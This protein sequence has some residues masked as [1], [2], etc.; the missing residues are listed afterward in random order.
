MSGGMEMDPEA[1]QAFAAVLAD[2]KGKFD[3]V[4]ARFDQSNATAEDFGRSWHEHGTLF[5]NSWGKLAPD[6]GSLSILLEQI[7]AQLGQTAELV[8]TGETAAV[9]DF[10]KIKDHDTTGSGAE[11][12]SAPPSSAGSMGGFPLSDAWDAF[13]AK[14]SDDRTINQG[15]ADVIRGPRLDRA[16]QETVPG[17]MKRLELGEE[18][19]AMDQRARLLDLNWGKIEHDAGMLSGLGAAM[20][21]LSAVLS[22]GAAK[23]GDTWKG[24]SY[25]S[26]RT[27]VGK[28]TTTLTAYAQGATDTGDG[29]TAAM[30][31][32]RGLYEIYAQETVDKHLNFD[33]VSPPANWHK[34]TNDSDNDHS[35]ASLGRACCGTFLCD[36]YLAGMILVNT[37][38]TD[39]QWATCLAA[40]CDNWGVNVQGTIQN[41]A[42]ECAKRVRDIDEQIKNFKNPT[43]ETVGHVTEMMDLAVGNLVE[44]AEDQVLSSLAIIGG[45]GTTPANAGDYSGGGGDYPGGGSYPGSGGGSAGGAGSMPVATPP[46]VEM[47]EVP[48]ASEVPEFAPEAVEPPADGVTPEQQETVRIQDGD[49]AISVSSPDGSGQVRVTVEDASGATKS[50]SLDFD[51]ASGLLPMGQDPAAAAEPA[52][53]PDGKPI[54]DEAQKIPA[55]TNGK[56]VIEDGPL[57]ITAERPLFAPDSLRLVVDD[58][59]GEPTTYTV[60]FAEQA[61]DPTGAAAGLPAVAPAPGGDQEIAPPAAERV[62]EDV[63]AEPEAP[64]E[65]EPLVETVDAE[66]PV[67]EALVAEP[68]AETEESEAPPVDVVESTAPQSESNGTGAMSGRLPEPG[69]AELGVAADDNGDTGVAAA[70][71]PM[72]GGA[73]AQGDSGDA[74][75][76]I[77]SGWSVHGDLFDSGEPVYSMRGVLGDDERDAE[78]VSR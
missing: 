31:N 78:Q 32:I 75:G 64:A 18:H 22:G 49:R 10:N 50:Y 29:L 25:Q 9:G 27:A 23:L 11:E 19:V 5:V 47:P 54:E 16:I 65:D 21:D 52:V 59:T 48:E 8:V 12:S 36:K 42:D 15:F 55:S 14:Q 61:D 68:Q 44:L 57:T 58:G 20:A 63:V 69:E 30:S 45:G 73:G 51:A 39:N 40:S 74:G 62:A 53:G 7:Q 66:Q 28:I 41:V 77:S 35:P 13:K 4:K 17:Y 72:L 24:E 43:D 38:V 33:Y 34:V 56:C 76:R 67:P 70:G 1:L 71:M 2:A 37:F 6:L 26:F 60:D 46:P 3:K